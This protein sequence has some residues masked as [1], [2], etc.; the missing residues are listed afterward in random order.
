MGPCFRRDNIL[1]FLATFR[2]IN[3]PDDTKIVKAA[4]PDH[5]IQDALSVAEEI[6]R[7]A[8]HR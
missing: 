7:R 2:E 6:L 3:F 4:T 8:L 5:I 1:N